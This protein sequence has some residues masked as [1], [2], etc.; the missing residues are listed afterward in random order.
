MFEKMKSSLPFILLWLSCVN[1]CERNLTSSPYL[2][3]D[4]CPERNP[5]YD[6]EADSNPRECRNWDACTWDMG[7]CPR[8][9]SNSTSG[10]AP[11]VRTP[12]PSSL[13][14]PT[15]QPSLYSRPSKAPTDSPT[16]TGKGTERPTR[17]SKSGNGGVTSFPTYV[18]TVINKVTKT[19]TESPAPS[20]FPSAHPSATPSNTP[21]ASPSDF[22][23]LYPTWISRSKIKCP[24]A[25]KWVNGTE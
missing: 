23:S 2:I 1:S 24:L 7:M 14:R 3:V 10:P 19:P 5:D 11:G 4:G 21:S 12:K 9:D 25:T 8:C 15:T 13:H 17:G 18:T 16:E 20:D 6:R 22:P